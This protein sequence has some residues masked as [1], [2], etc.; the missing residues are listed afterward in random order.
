ML[1]DV[2]F[3]TTGTSGKRKLL[4]VGSSKVLTIRSALML[5]SAADAAQVAEN[6]QAAVDDGNFAEIFNEVA[7]A[8][9]VMET[10]AIMLTPPVQAAK[11]TTELI[12]WNT[13]KLSETAE[14]IEWLMI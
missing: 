2:Y 9:W 14:A 7:N 11:L 1:P 12:C 4:E 3:S 10:D 5:N 8:T 6:I 13:M